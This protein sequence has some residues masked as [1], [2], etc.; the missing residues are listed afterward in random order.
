MEGMRNVFKISV[1]KIKGKGSI[2]RPRRRYDTNEEVILAVD[3]T[4]PP[5]FELTFCK[6]YT[7]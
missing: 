4:H 7:A 5:S 6:E 2:G 1:T 3:G